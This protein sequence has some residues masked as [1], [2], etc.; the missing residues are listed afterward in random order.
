M[1]RLS[2]IAA[3]GVLTTALA[4]PVM[5]QQMSGW[6]GPDR[7]YSRDYRAERGYRHDRNYDSNAFWPAD[8]AAGVVG[9]AIGTAGAITAAPFGGPDA[10][11]YDDSYAKRNGFV[12]QPGTWF[13]GE[14][15]RMHPCQ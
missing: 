4:T 6:N 7:S 2:I 14:D 9:G 3:A 5:A 1:S 8:V 13:R 15:G 10:Y 12:C 11:A